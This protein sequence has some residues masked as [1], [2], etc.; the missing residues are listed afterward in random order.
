MTNSKLHPKPATFHQASE[1][2]DAWLDLPHVQILYPGDRHWGLL[3]ELGVATRASG[4]FITDVAI[5]AT[6][7]EYG[8]VVHTNDRDFARFPN[9]RWHNP[10]NA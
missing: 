3:K 5:A 7:L 1:I 9:L 10:L 8:A 6:A 2:V 4:K